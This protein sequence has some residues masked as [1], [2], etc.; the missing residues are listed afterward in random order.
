[1]LSDWHDDEAKVECFDLR[2]RVKELEAEIRKLKAMI[3]NGLGWEDMH[4]DIEPV[5]ESR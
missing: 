1:M 3:D 5:K 4:N 2:L